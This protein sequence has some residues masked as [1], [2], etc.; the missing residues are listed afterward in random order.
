MSL[1]WAAPGLK[2]PHVVGNDWQSRGLAGAATLT[3]Y[4]KFA[5]LAT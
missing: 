2:I 5:K 4:K 1:P 3:C